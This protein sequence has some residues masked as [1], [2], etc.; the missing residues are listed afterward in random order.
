MI[1]P[2]GGAVQEREENAGYPERYSSL[3]FSPADGHW[4]TGYET[5]RSSN[6]NKKKFIFVKVLLQQFH[7]RSGPGV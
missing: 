6:K 5:L 2:C 3:V 7:R 4:N 1:N